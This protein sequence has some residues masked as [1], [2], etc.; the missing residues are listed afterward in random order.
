M[1][2]EEDKQLPDSH[3]EGA[4]LDDNEPVRFVWER[5]VKQSP[6]NARMRARI[7]ADII[8]NRQ[9][10]PHV[11]DKDFIPDSLESVFDQAFSTLRQKSRVQRDTTVALKRRKREAVK[12]SKGRR[13]T[14]KRAVRLIPTL[15]PVN[16]FID[17]MAETG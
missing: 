8:H 5:T 6:H 1:G 4:P 11:P 14:R 12:S 2:M 3:I 13:A 17:I 7:I 10:Y 15:P 9:L 16:L